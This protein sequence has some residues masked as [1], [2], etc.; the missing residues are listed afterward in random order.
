M[1]PARNDAMAVG[2]TSVE[3]AIDQEARDGRR[4]II[5]RNT[6][7][8]PADTITLSLGGISAVAGSGIILRQNDVFVDSSDA[9]YLCHQNQILGV[10]ATING[11]V[12]VMER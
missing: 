6:S 10:C 4:A 8:N 7:P 2:T 1:I 12:S 9:G 5:I 3:I 11:T